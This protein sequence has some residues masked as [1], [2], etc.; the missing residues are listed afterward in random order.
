MPKLTR[1]TCTI[2]RMHGRNSVGHTASYCAYVGGPYAGRMSEAIADKRAADKE[3]KPA[4][5]QTAFLSQIKQSEKT[6]LD[7]F[8]LIEDRLDKLESFTKRV[9]TFLK[10]NHS[11]QAR[12]KPQTGTPQPTPQQTPPTR[13][14]HVHITTPTPLPTTQSRWVWHPDY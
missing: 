10:K 6:V 14:Q 5:N 1:D 7:R 12:R 2:C 13:Q 11:S 4:K 9:D 3:K 8:K